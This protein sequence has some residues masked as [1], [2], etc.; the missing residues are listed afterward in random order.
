[1]PSGSGLFSDPSSHLPQRGSPLREWRVFTLIKLL[2]VI[3]IMA[4]AFL[5]TGCGKKAQ[6]PAPVSPPAQPVVQPVAEQNNETT[7][8]TNTE[9]LTVTTT[10]TLPPGYFQ[11]TVSSSATNAM[12]VE[13][14]D[15]VTVGYEVRAWMRAHGR[16]PKDWEEF[17]STCGHQFSPPPPGK[18]YAFDN[19]YQ[20]VLVDK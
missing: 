15:P 1:M 3:A 20:G 2:A 7:A 16:A 18:K 11:P 19:R 10:S 14:M 4:A 12:E 9:N 13:K 5:L 17:A 8:P 6:A